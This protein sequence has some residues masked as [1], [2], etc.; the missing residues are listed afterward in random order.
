VFLL[1]AFVRTPSAQSTAI[2]L[3]TVVPENSIWD[4][5]LKQMATE[6]NEATG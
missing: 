3:A 4:R 2:K 1:V 6:W 5:N